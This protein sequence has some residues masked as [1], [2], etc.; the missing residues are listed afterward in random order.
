MIIYYTDG[1]DVDEDKVTITSHGCHQNMESWA[2]ITCR[3]VQ[4]IPTDFGGYAASSTVEIFDI[5]RM[6]IM[7][8]K[9]WRQP[10]FK[11][12]VGAN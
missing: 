2:G 10:R 6:I 5:I 8:T 7:S 12:D 1:H 9:I 11:V 3:D 4:Y